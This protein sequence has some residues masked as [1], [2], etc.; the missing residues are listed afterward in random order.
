MAAAL[1]L[2]VVRFIVILVDVGRR[3]L[4]THDPIRESCGG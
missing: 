1:L 3:S 2:L 4:W